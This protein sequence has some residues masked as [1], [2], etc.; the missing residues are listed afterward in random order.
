M[1]ELA[2]AKKVE[3]EEKLEEVEEAK[4]EE[5][6]FLRN[7]ARSEPL[8]LFLAEEDIGI[9]IIRRKKI[10]GIFFLIENTFFQSAV[11]WRYLGKPKSK[12][13]R[14]FIGGGRRVGGL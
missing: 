4:E 8:G 11:F 2:R 5:S 14:L 7:V 13:R 10:F 6:E 9:R 12:E 3:E 1:G